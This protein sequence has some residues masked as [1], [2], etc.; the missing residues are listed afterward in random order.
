[1]RVCVVI[2]HRE[3]ACLNIGWIVD[4]QSNELGINHLVNLSISIPKGE[5]V[6]ERHKEKARPNIEVNK[7]FVSPQ[8]SI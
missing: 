3:V 2:K 8:S 1:M 7:W 5:Q 4:K 6:W